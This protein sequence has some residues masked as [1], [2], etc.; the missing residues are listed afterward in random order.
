MAKGLMGIVEAVRNRLPVL[1]GTVEAERQVET[2]CP[3]RGFQQ[4]PADNVTL[5]EAATEPVCP[6]THR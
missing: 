4:R 6:V 1:R 2:A 3:D 5:R